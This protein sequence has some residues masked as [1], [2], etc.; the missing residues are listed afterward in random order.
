MK[1]LKLLVLSGAILGSSLA[2]RAENAQAWLENYYRNPQ[3]AEL[4]RAVHALSREGYFEQPR[5][6]PVAIGFLSTVFAQNPDRIEGWLAQ[7]RDLPAKDQRLIAAALWQ[8]GNPLGTDALQRLGQSSPVRDEVLRLANTPG[9]SVAATPVHSPSSMN[10]QWGAFLA[11]GSE[12]HILNILDAI[13]TNQPGL[14]QAARISLAQNAATHPR[15]LEI[16]RAQLARMPVE[17]RS[18]LRAALLEATAQP[19][20]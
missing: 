17:P 15:V 12:R 16:C 14:D 2:A 19:R 4:A 7:T 11:S 6:I 13:G 5:N 10:L 8:S 20:S 1:T 9:Q 18:E 3:P